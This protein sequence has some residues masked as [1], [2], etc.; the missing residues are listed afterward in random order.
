MDVRGDT[1]QT[2]ELLEFHWFSIKELHQ[3]MAVA[4][5]VFLRLLNKILDLF[6]FFFAKR[7]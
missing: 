3:V 4:L 6:H 2:P 1:D 5:A 7:G